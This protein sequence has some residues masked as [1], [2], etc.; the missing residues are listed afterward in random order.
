MVLKRVFTSSTALTLQDEFKVKV[1]GGW[2]GV[3]DLNC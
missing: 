2:E 3:G 1:F